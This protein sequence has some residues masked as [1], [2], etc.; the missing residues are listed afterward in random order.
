VVVVALGLLLIIAIGVSR[1]YLGVHWPSDVLAG[2]LVGGLWL[3]VCHA[4]AARWR[5]RNPPRPTVENDEA[6]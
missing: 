1:F 3:A 6:R 4:L 2:W 5:D